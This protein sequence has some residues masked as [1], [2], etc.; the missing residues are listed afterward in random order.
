M[1]TKSTHLNRVA[2][3]GYGHVGTTSAYSLLMNSTVEELVLINWD[4][5][6]LIGEVMDLQHAVSLARPIR[7]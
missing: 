7:I 3:I 4:E 6:T 1:K 2:I 5:F